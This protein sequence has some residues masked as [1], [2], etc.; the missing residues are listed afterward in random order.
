MTKR[1]KERLS[2]YKER[3]A[4]ASS[5]QPGDK[6]VGYFRDSGGDDQDRSVDEQKI[7][8]YAECNRL[9]LVPYKLFEE[10]IR[11]GTTTKGRR[12]FRAMFDYFGE[13]GRADHDGVRG[14]LLYSFSRFARDEDDAPYFVSSLRRQGFIVKSI[15]DKIPDGDFSRIAEAFTFFKDA[16][17]SRDLSKLVTRGQAH[18]LSNYR[19][20]GGLYILPTTGEAVQL[21][22][23]GFP[24]LG[25][26]RFLVET[27]QNRRGTPRFNS[28]WK[29]TA[30]T[31][32]AG[33]VRLAWEMV[34]AGA[35]YDEIEKAC[36][37]GRSPRSYNAMFT[38]VTY[39]GLYSFGDFN[40]ENAFEAY[41][42]NEEYQRVQEIIDRRAVGITKRR[43][44]ARRY[45]L[46]GLV[47][48]GECSS[49]AHGE[50]LQSGN[51]K[52]ITYYYQCASRKILQDQHSYLYKLRA[53]HLEGLVFQFLL[54]EVLDEQ[55]V[56]AL[57]AS[58]AAVAERAFNTP[59][60][61]HKVSEL[62]T[63]ITREGEQ[64]KKLALQL[65]TTAPELGIV[66]EVKELISEA[67]YRR[68]QAEADL[69]ALNMV[70]VRRRL[71]RF[72]ANM[73]MI[74]DAR[75]T[76]EAVKST[77]APS[78]QC[79]G[80]KRFDQLY[81]L[82][83]ALGL[84]I[85]LYPG[86]YF[87]DETGDEDDQGPVQGQGAAVRECGSGSNVDAEVVSRE[88]GTVL[89]E[90][91][92]S[93]LGISGANGNTPVHEKGKKIAPELKISGAN[94]HAP[95]EIRTPDSRFRRPML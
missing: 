9:K 23:G 86:G 68:N 47:W 46:S 89:L 38:T 31:D 75:A 42:T 57:A 66:D 87:L 77:G 24:P 5:F 4:S 62:E 2:K 36:T 27:G 21:I 59:D 25:Y 48:C 45:L 8:W 80:D 52:Y 15:V 41:V 30:D 64:I 74:R 60:V 55:K 71:A 6:V 28:Y 10:R 11:S 72:K 29:K 18:V 1:T 17:F 40:R 82:L 61:T 49:P 16:Q 76:I 70:D 56:T 50:K 95:G 67:R 85:T 65:A 19:N 78:G 79:P 7:D 63:I 58:R 33:R 91:N 37:F 34:L 54:D 93:V 94:D 90:C 73:A 83:K 20:D 43:P 12:Q 44:A 39:T 92:L 13:S 26:D 22:A 51:K 14:L 81:R 35:S 53:E 3:A 84:K 69:E 32:L 88:M